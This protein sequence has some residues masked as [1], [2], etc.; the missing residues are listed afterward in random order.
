MRRAMLATSAVQTVPSCLA[1]MDRKETKR[2]TRA[3]PPLAAGTYNGRS[4]SNRGVV[5][6]ASKLEGATTMAGA[7]ARGDELPDEGGSR[8]R[9]DVAGC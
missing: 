7:I 3:P 2:L 4:E 8:S 1:S 5:R 9:H 6:I